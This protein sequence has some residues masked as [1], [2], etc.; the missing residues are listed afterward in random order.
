MQ[1]VFLLACEG[2][3]VSERLLQIMS[4]AVRLLHCK[5]GHPQVK[6]FMQ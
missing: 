3:Q 1:C 2:M 6:Q 4:I 5:D